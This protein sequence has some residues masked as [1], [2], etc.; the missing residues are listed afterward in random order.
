[1]QL[2]CLRVAQRDA[3][4]TFPFDR[5]YLVRYDDR[6]V[7]EKLFR[8]ALVMPVEETL[9]EQLGALKI[10]EAKNRPHHR[11]D[12]AALDVAEWQQA[13]TGTEWVLVV[14]LL[15]KWMHKNMP[16]Y[17]TAEKW[18]N[19][20]Y[21]ADG[22]KLS[23]RRRRFSSKTTRESP[24]NSRAYLQTPQKKI[25]PVCVVCPRVILHQNGECKLGER[26]CYESLPLGIQ[27]HFS[28][29]QAIPDA[30]PNS[31]EPEEYEL[32]EGEEFVVTP[33]APNSRAKDLLRI[34][35]E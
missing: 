11:D 33:P 5:V 8:Y 19:D 15:P 34:I 35:N 9:L 32:V 27:D 31:L 2:Y 21:P 29:A 16:R 14:P 3:G 10:D 1:M 22:Q 24:F 30:P 7:I 6:A 25:R 12:E 23:R 13:L 17:L 26:V 28:E 20:H 4:K 18:F